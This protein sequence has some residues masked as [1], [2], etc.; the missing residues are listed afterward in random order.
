ME[1]PVEPAV[2]RFSGESAAGTWTRARAA[3]GAQARAVASAPLRTSGRLL[4]RKT[5][6]SALNTHLLCGIG[7]R[8]EIYASGGYFKS[9]QFF[10]PRSFFDKERRKSSLVHTVFQKGHEKIRKAHAQNKDGP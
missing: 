3:R 10:F 5:L 4:R 6:S 9:K 2:C 1:R 7:S 8:L